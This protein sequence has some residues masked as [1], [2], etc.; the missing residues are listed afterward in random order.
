MKTRETIEE[1]FKKIVD[2]WKKDNV[3]N[4]NKGDKAVSKRRKKEPPWA[5]YVPS[6]QEKNYKVKERVTVP[7]KH[8][9]ACTRPCSYIFSSDEEKENCL[10]Y[11]MQ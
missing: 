1:E 3:E 11:Y 2:M 7:L 5:R 4:Q 10:F 9:D 6:W 8:C